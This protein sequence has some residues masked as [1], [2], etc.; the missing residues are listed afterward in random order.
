MDFTNV[1]S[2]LRFLPPRNLPHVLVPH[3]PFGLVYLY[4]FT[5]YT[6]L[7][8]FAGSVVT[9]RLGYLRFYALPRLAVTHT[10]AWVVRHTRF[11]HRT[12]RVHCLPHCRVHYTVPAVTTVACV[13][14][15]WLRFAF[16]RGLHCVYRFCCP[17]A[18]RL[19]F[20]F[21]LPVT[22]LPLRYVPVTG[23]HVYCG[24]SRCGYHWFNTHATP[25]V[26]VGC[27]IACRSVTL[28]WFWFFV[29][30]VWFTR[31]YI[32]GCTSYYTVTAFT[33][34]VYA[35]Y[36]TLV[37]LHTCVRT[38][39]AHG[40]CRTR[41]T[42][43]ARGYA[44]RYTVA[45]RTVTRLLPVC[46]QHWFW[47]LLLRFWL[48]R[49]TGYTLRLVCGSTRAVAHT[50]HTPACPHHTHTRF[51]CT[52]FVPL[53]VLVRFAVHVHRYRLD[54]PLIPLDYGSTVYHC[55][56]VIPLPL[57]RFTRGWFLR[58]CYGLLFTH[59]PAVYLPARHCRYLPHTL[60]FWLPQFP[61]VHFGCRM[62]YPFTTTTV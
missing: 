42:L 57:P 54:Y 14:P 56:P 24:W 46:I 37:P 34:C 41:F 23:Y 51:A 29:L 27:R 17:F 7:P 20:W 45:T 58:F 28:V 18:L 12:H 43:P 11:V 31:S 59:L 15:A 22:V 40:Y 39:S 62:V 2:V 6:V 35:D 60:P 8:R 47:F 30:H 13:L 53:L 19:R 5:C 44:L 48:P 3:L 33:L 9:L 50:L 21:W 38:G 16:T 26:L 1:G 4:T 61:T 49:H 10:T 36:N 55:L 52:S 25:F 32:Y